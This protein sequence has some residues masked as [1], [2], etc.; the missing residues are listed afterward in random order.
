MEALPI[1]G[2]VLGLSWLSR[3]NKSKIQQESTQLENKVEEIN[4]KIKK[5]D[6]SSSRRDLTNYLRELETLKSLLEK[7]ISYVEELED[8]S[9]ECMQNFNPVKLN[10]SN[11]KEILIMNSKAARVTELMLEDQEKLISEFLGIDNNL[12]PNITEEEFVNTKRGLKKYSDLKIENEKIKENYLSVR[13]SFFV[14]EKSRKK[15][16]RIRSAKSR[17]SSAE[18]K[19]EWT[20][21]RAAD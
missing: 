16:K 7:E 15:L 2:M 6:S 12:N 19:S 20:R 9:I 21:R 18:K 1:K 3:S 13:N 8:V 5:L 11:E 14:V 17:S 4:S 10:P